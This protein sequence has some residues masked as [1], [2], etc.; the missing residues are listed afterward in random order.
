MRCFGPRPARAQG[1]LCAAGEKAAIPAK[2][3][4]FVCRHWQ[5]LHNRAIKRPPFEHDIP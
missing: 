2:G 3:I 5:D 1:E 4:D